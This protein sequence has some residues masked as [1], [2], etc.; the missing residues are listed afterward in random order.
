M[1]K[2]SE[3]I[4]GKPTRKKITVI[5]GILNFVIPVIT[6]VGGFWWST[7]VFA[8]LMRYNPHIV[9]YPLFR[10]PSGYPVYN[11]F[12]YFGCFIKYFLRP[13]F[14][15]YL[16]RSIKPALI[17][18]AIAIGFIILYVIRSLRQKEVY[19]YGTARWATKK[20]LKNAGMFR[21]TGV[22][23]GQT[24]DAKISAEYNAKDDAVRLKT[25]SEGKKL[26]C[27]SGKTNT[28]CLAPTRSGKGVSVIIPTLLNYPHSVIVFDPKGEN[29]NITAGFRKQFSHCLKFSPISRDT[30][31]INIIDEIRDGDFMYSDANL[32]ADILFA[33][34]NAK[35]SG[36]EQFFNNSAKDFVTG[37]ILHVKYSDR[38]PAKNLTTVLRLISES[39]A[40]F[41]QG[42][43]ET[44]IKNPLVEAMLKDLHSG[45]KSA[46]KTISGC[47]NRL[48]KNPKVQA[49]VL[50]TCFSKLQLFEDPLI[51]NATCAS[52][53]SIEDFISTKTP[54]SLYLTVPY[55]HIKR[56]APVFRLLIE[57]MLRKFSEGETQY[58]AVKLPEDLLFILDGFPILG[59][60]PFLAET[61]GV[62][63]GYGVRFL[64]ICQAMNQLVKLYGQEHPFLD[65]CENTIVFRPR[66]PSDAKVFTDL[67]GKESVVH[68]NISQSGRRFGP[69]DN[70][71]LAAQD[72]QRDLMNPD[73]LTKLDWNSLLLIN[74]GMPYIGKKVVYF[75]SPRFKDR[76]NMSVPQK[77]KDLL[78][79]C[80]NLPSNKGI[81]ILARSA[82]VE[83]AMQKD[84]PL[85]LMSRQDVRKRK[86][87]L[88]NATL[89]DFLE[90]LPQERE[91]HF[92]DP[93]DPPIE[94]LKRR[95]S[96][97]ELQMAGESENEWENQ[98][99]EVF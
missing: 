20:D 88:E 62:L 65:H 80:V 13:G 45:N 52:D 99:H 87:T 46:C 34:D 28:L 67:L 91:R 95:I 41:S 89:A 27:H 25:I 74:N 82:E 69:L 92:C 70:R 71:N 83:K 35:D 9:R 57:F 94:E 22:V 31:R 72:I 78:S 30:L 85:F 60:F 73:E 54:I 56:I 49:D 23:C 1:S 32:I 2:K 16:F 53:F 61:M 55:A 90:P 93:A 51:E 66:K 24:A 10:F 68:E 79:E 97:L 15:V 76:A 12:V 64:I 42:Q 11:P 75:D 40:F 77:R 63:A 96:M 43:T 6:V 33:G 44:D 19:L 81:D 47:A 38:Y 26:L 5:M 8:R 7:Q 17:G 14:D 50:S 36:T 29:W 21:E 48:S 86:I 84:T 39:N 3:F 4:R 18:T 98:D 59:Y 58:G 37:V